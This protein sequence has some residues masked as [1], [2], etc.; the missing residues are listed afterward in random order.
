MQ[1]RFFDHDTVM[2]HSNME[3]IKLMTTID[4]CDLAMGFGVTPTN[5]SSKA[6]NHLDKE[7]GSGAHLCPACEVV[8]WNFGKGSGI[9]F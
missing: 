1:H 4:Y 5:S 6:R 8:I 3:I 2:K 9:R 7:F